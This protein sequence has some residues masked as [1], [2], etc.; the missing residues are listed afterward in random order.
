[1]RGGGR[2]FAFICVMV[3]AMV[4]LVPDAQARMKIGMVVLIGCED[5]C[6]GVKDYI[7]EREIDA[8]VVVYDRDQMSGD[9]SEIVAKMRT[10][11]VD[12]AI[13]WGTKG[14]YAQSCR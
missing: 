3:L 4:G 7:A 8:D 6:R 12:L 10:A 1:M 2:I 14:T 9:I 13:T 5:V 11:H